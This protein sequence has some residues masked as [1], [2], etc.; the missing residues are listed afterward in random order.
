[1]RKRKKGSY[2]FEKS[3]NLPCNL[4]SD[5][6]RSN[7]R[8]CDHPSCTKGS[9]SKVVNESHTNVSS[10]D[11][12]VKIVVRYIRR[13]WQ[14][15]LKRSNISVLGG[16]SPWI[17]NTVFQEKTHKQKRK[18][19]VRTK[20]VNINVRTRILVNGSFLSS[21]FSTP[22]HPSFFSFLRIS[23]LVIWPNEEETVIS[24]SV[25]S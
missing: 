7:V 25:W 15:S 17:L 20:L 10:L 6:T 16:G 21:F 13:K 5:T 1:M 4:S 11:I 14:L 22:L 2:R 24:V 19:L 12:P 23:I 9:S 3:G 8:R 18:S